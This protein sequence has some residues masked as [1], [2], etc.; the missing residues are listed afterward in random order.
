MRT[1]SRGDGGVQQ[2]GDPGAASPLSP[3]SY[4]YGKP[5]QGKVQADLCLSQKPWHR[6]GKMTCTQVTGQVSVA[7]TGGVTGVAP[8]RECC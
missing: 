2:S 4:T 7:G 1:G 6:W 5:V 3:H 8:S